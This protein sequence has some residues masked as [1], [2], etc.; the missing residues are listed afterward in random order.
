MLWFSRTTGAQLEEPQSRNASV[1]FMRHVVNRDVG[2]GR[3]NGHTRCDGT[4]MPNTADG[5][6]MIG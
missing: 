4:Q 2:D 5:F 3:P 6:T 1:H